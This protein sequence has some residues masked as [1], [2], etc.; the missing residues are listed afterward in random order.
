MPLSVLPVCL[1]HYWRASMRV[2]MCDVTNVSGC[3]LLP[4]YVSTHKTLTF[5]HEC[6]IRAKQQ[7]WQR[8]WQKEKKNEKKKTVMCQTY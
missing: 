1:S 6:W 3:S 8:E 7:K 5:S 4:M 2:H